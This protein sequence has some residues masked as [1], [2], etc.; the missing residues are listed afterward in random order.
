[1]ITKKTF[2]KFTKKY[3]E[4]TKSAIVISHRQGWVM[5]MR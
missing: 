1:M 3:Q 2:K 5:K 4:R